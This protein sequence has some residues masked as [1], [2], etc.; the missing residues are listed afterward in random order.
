MWKYQVVLIA[1][2][3]GQGTTTAVYHEL[4]KMGWKPDMW[5]AYKMTAL[6]LADC[7]TKLSLGMWCPSQ[8]VDGYSGNGLS[9]YM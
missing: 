3:T 9:E 7:T 5:E 1:A 2:A 8:I 6:S 4:I